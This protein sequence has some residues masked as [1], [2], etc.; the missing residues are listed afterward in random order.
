MGERTLF[1]LLSPFCSLKLYAFCNT[2]MYK[3]TTKE[4]RSQRFCYIYIYK[5]KKGI[6]NKYKMIKHEKPI[7]VSMEKNPPESDEREIEQHSADLFS[8]LLSPVCWVILNTIV[9]SLFFWAFYYLIISFFFTIWAYLKAPIHSNWPDWSIM[10]IRYCNIAIKIFYYY[11]CDVGQFTHNSI[12]FM[13]FKVNN[14]VNLQW[15]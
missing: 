8:S 10:I 15:F 4:A 9:S 1:L 11:Y 5:K 14:Y 12:N 7:S 2:R 6:V 3:Q 13:N